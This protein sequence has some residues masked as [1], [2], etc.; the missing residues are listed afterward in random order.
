MGAL[1]LWAAAYLV[2][3]VMVLAIGIDQAQAARLLSFMAADRILNWT[4][5]L[6]VTPACVWLAAKN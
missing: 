2:Y 4:F 6:A 3:A 5:I 1:A